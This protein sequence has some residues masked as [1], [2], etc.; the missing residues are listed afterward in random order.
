M[1]DEIELKLELTPDAANAFEASSLML[2][3]PQRAEHIS[4]YFDTPDHALNARGLALRIRRSGR[5]RLQTVK[6]SSACAAGLFT[7]SEWERALRSDKPILDDTTPIRAL[8]GD[9]VDTIAPVFEVRITRHKWLVSEGGA[10]IELVLDRGEAL[11]GDRKSPICEIELELKEGDP[12]ALFGLARR[13]GMVVPVR[14]G[15]QTKSERGYRLAGPVATMFKAEPVALSG[16]MTADQAFRHIVYNC[17]RQFRLNEALLLADRN[18]AALHQARVALRRLRS[19]FSIFKPLVGG[20]TKTR[21]SGELRW[22]SSQLGDARNL[23]VLLELAT[24]SALHD[25]I[26]T[27]HEAAYV[28]V[29][30]V[31]ASSRVRSLLL[32]LAEWTAGDD[33]LNAPDTGVDHDQSAR[34]FAIAALSRF[35]RKVKKHGR[36]LVHADD[37]TRHE[38]RKDAKKLRYAAEFFAGLFDHESEKPRYRNFMGSLEGLLHQL[39]QLND[40]ATAS[41]LLAELGIADDPEAVKLL[42]RGRKK[43]SLNAAAGSYDALIEAKRFWRA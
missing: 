14:L 33:W 11:V 42:A 3:E 10:M 19:A 18:A 31:L 29:G 12:V 9:A 24:T 25:R 34:E 23:D 37:A 32:D 40:L 22:L 4:V 6:V 36:D 39:G 15:V 28:R 8:L 27:A 26:V 7:R 43:T 2:G 17:V 35:R 20:D 41:C 5:K 38:T 1:A 13:I 30:D 21:L 16:D